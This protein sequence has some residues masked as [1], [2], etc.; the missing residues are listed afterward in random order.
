MNIS[1]FFNRFGKV[2]LILVIS[3]PLQ[4]LFFN[5]FT[6]DSKIV[7]SVYSNGIFRFISIVLRSV[8]YYIPFSLGE[9]LLWI[10][11]AYILYRVYR[12]VKNI[13][14]KQ[15]SCRKLLIRSL[16]TV[17]SAYAVVYFLFMISWG[18]NY[19][20]VSFANMA[21]LQLEDTNSIALSE[22]CHDLVK[23]T[24]AKRELLDE[25]SSGVAKLPL[26]L[27][28]Y[29]K[30]AQTG[31]KKEAFSQ[32]ELDLTLLRA[33][34]IQGSFLFNLLGVGGIYNPFTAEANVN[35]SQPDPFI[36]AVICHEIA[37]Q[38]GF[39]PENEANFIAFRTSV[40]NPDPYF[41]YSGFLLATRYCLGTL[42]SVDQ[43]EYN[44]LLERLDDG[45]KR[46]IKAKRKF[47]EKH[48]SWI[49]DISSMFY[50]FYLK[51]NSQDEGIKSYGMVV[52][53]LVADY[54]KNGMRE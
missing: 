37:H 39:A 30:N 8:T 27:S 1:N 29:L 6:S 9:L 50:D 38:C 44:F 49:S 53:L 11:I 19:H 33:K 54:K 34:K 4:M 43:Q 7:E 36:P 24:N 47:W 17:L 3:I 2:K 40:S 10:A 12:F 5:L 32:K 51:S 18:I 20:R 46:D 31:F 52:K 13:I 14:A 16:L 22:L 28:Y 41:Q 45:V 48:T 15:E 26:K 23:I 21:E 35:C 42:Y 25:D